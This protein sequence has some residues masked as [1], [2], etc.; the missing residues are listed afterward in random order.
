MR[1]E[2]GEQTISVFYIDLGDREIKDTDDELLAMPPA[3]V[4][5]NTGGKTVNSAQEDKLMGEEVVIRLVTDKATTIDKCFINIEQIT[6]LP[7][8]VPV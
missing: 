7:G 1:T 5:V 4:K 8:I 6:L 2:I 3:V